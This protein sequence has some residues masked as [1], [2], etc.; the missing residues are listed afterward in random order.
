MDKFGYE[1][2]KREKICLVYIVFIKFISFIYGINL[3]A[4]VDKMSK[5]FYRKSFRFFLLIVLLI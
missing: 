1:E 2:K 4:C 3:L 5:Y